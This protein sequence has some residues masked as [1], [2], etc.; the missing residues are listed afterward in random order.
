[1][2]TWARRRECRFAQGASHLNEVS[3]RT[4]H[5]FAQHQVPFAH[6]EV[7]KTAFLAGAEVMFAGFP[8]KEKI[9]EQISRFQPTRPLVVVRI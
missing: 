6:A 7:F 5:S 3:Y 1:M 9:V 2:H 8:N 4:C